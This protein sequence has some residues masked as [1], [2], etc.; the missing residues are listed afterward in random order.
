MDIREKTLAGLIALFALVTIT[1]L[2]L[3]LTIFPESYRAIETKDMTDDVGMILFDIHDEFANLEASTSDWGPWDE[4]YAFAQGENPAFAGENLAKNT[5][6]NLGLNFIVITNSTGSIIYGQSYNSTNGSFSPL[7]A[8][9]A[10]AITTDP[11]PLRPATVSRTSGFLVF[12]SFTAMA[13]SYPIL[14]SNLTGPPAGTLVMGRYLDDTE[15]QS[16]G[17]PSQSP[18]SFS[19]AVTG[20]NGVPVPT[21]QVSTVNDE[22]IEGKTTLKDIYGN[23]ALVL[24]FQKSRDF[25]QQGKQT[26]QFFLLVQLAIMLLF[27]VF[28]VYRIDNSILVR[29]N[30]IIKDTRAVSDGSA[31]RIKKSGDDE[32]THLAD[33]MN[34]MIERIEQSH[35]DLRDSEEKFRSF[36][37]EAADGYVLVGSSGEVLEWN[38][39]NER[40]TGIPREEALG[41]PF[42]DILIRLLVPEHR[43]PEHIDSVRHASESIV[44]TGESPHFYRSQEIAIQRPDGTRRILQQTTFPIRISGQLLFGIINHDITERRLT[45]DALQQS[46]RKL[47]LLN[48]VTFQDVG[49]AIFALSGFHELAESAVTGKEGMEFLKKED[50]LIRQI[51]LSLKAAKD[52]QDLG[53]NPPRWQDVNQVF[54]FALS[55]L[56]TTGISRTVRLEGVE[57]FADPLLEKVFF[58]LLENRF[59][60]GR[61]VTTISLTSRKVEAGLELILEDN[62]RGIPAGEKGMIFERGYSDGLGLFLVREILSITDITI[63]ETGTEANGARFT[64]GVPEGMYRFN[65][66][67][68]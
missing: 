46:R 67:Q 40:I 34:E 45:E 51:D 15:I 49:S 35:T 18:P 53:I 24:T 2:V 12:P 11:S 61:G 7:P 36:V 39:A 32:I 37:R 68:E 28:I 8:D 47:N 58:N 60:N 41:T 54:I 26:I 25:Y 14:H 6:D 31:L 63:Q 13:A 56:D 64:I 27:G 43:T 48:T 44:R 10:R 33:A 20:G 22:I 66:E 5:F 16:I 59:H 30:S 57:I 65:S 19:H 4:F 52:Y 62:G 50:R 3:S 38:A 29:L 9:L 23:D 42:V 21:V 17:L 55:H 1:L